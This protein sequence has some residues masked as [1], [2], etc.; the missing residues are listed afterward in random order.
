MGRRRQA[1]EIA[2]KI[3]FQID[4]GKLNPEEVLQYYL[5]GK[6]GSGE[7][8]KYAEQLS[9]G[10]M[11]EL[12]AIDR[13]LAEKALNWEL[14]RLESV[15]R[16]LLRLATYELLR[17]PD[18]PK[19]VIINEAIEMAKKYSTEDSSRFIN[20]ILDKIVQQAE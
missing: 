2:L 5:G 11:A 12:P 16:N 7:A 20:G 18:I 14:D 6:Q 13:L 4:V 9:R 15:D 17:S 8:E 10:V 19:N 1:R 3:I